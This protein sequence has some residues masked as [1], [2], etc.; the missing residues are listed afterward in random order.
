MS[1]EFEILGIFVDTEL[2]LAITIS[3]HTQDLIM[4]NY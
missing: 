1:F 4:S 3:T 2:L